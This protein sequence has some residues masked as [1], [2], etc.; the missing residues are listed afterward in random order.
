VSNFQEVMQLLDAAEQRQRDE[1][2][3]TAQADREPVTPVQRHEEFAAELAA[4]LHAVQSDW[5]TL[6]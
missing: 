1:A 6:S 2:K 4:R 3:R 5:L